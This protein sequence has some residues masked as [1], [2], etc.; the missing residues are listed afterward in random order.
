MQAVSFQ[1][2]PPP[3]SSPVTHPPS[4]QGLCPAGTP[5]AKRTHPG[6]GHQHGRGGGGAE[7][8]V[9]RPRRRPGAGAEAAE[10]LP[11]HVVATGPAREGKGAALTANGNGQRPPRKRLRGW[12]GEQGARGRTRVTAPRLAGTPPWLRLS[13]RRR[14]RHFRR[15][16]G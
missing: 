3:T 15:E 8:A 2:E 16:R 14:L 1:E 4:W 9:Q 11:H 12:G 10:H 5:P 7:E 13:A 6:H